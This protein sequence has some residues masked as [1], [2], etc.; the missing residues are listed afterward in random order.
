MSHASTLCSARHA[1]HSPPLRVEQSSV[2]WT[3]SIKNAIPLSHTTFPDQFETIK[4]KGKYRYDTGKCKTLSVLRHY[5]CRRHNTICIDTIIL[6]NTYNTCIQLSPPR[7]VGPWCG[8]IK[9]WNQYKKAPYWAIRYLLNRN[10]GYC[11][12]SN[13]SD[14]GYW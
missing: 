6:Y 8:W 13:H 11:Q 10:I 12:Y 3:E 4:K 1:L 14:I 5:R 2:A 7:I 9:G